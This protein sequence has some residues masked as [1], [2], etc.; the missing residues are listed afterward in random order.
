MVNYRYAFNEMQQN[1]EAYAER[2]SIAISPEVLDY[3][4]H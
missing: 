4:R 2:G 3:L 1:H